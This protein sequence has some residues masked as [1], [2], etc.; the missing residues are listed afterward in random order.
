MNN[1]SHIESIPNRVFDNFSVYNND[2][3]D[4]IDCF[5]KAGLKVDHIITDPPY[6]ISQDNNFNTMR[7]PRQGVDFGKWDRGSFNLLAWI[8]KYAQL[9]NPNGSMIIFCSYRFLSYIV[10]TLENESDMLVKDVI[11]WQKRN[12]MPR[13][14]NRRYVQDMEF[15]VW[16]VKKN[17]KWT[18]NKPDGVSYLRALFSTSIVAGK[19]RLGH[20]TQKSLQ[21]MKDLIEIHTNKD[22]IIMDPFMGSGSTGDAALMLGRKFIGVEMSSEYYDI[23]LKRLQKYENL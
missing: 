12:P 4:Q 21:L 11:V 15:A 23:A 20:P 18:F 8:P 13:N 14:T 1:K 7:N 5:I 6:N 2:S 10:D 16:A 22:E 19:E 9:L 17:S 3:Y